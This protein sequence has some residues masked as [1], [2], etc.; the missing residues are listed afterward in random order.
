[1]PCK[2]PNVQMRQVEP[3]SPMPMHSVQVAR[4]C[5][6]RFAYSDR[7]EDNPE[8]FGL[9][10]PAISDLEAAVRVMSDLHGDDLHSVSAV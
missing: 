6:S 3:V 9:S 8:K 7:M 5:K 1:M 10:F 2:S 4:D